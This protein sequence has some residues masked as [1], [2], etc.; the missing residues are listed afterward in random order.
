M[1]NL[2]SLRGLTVTPSSTDADDACANGTATGGD[3]VPN[4]T[5]SVKSNGCST[6]TNTADVSDEKLEQTNGVIADEEEADQ[7][8]DSATTKKKKKKSKG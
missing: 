6:D 3:A 8:G 4:G 1:F 5:Y 7:D 2:F